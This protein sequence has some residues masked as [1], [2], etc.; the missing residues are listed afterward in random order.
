[1]FGIKKKT[2]LNNP[3]LKD[4]DMIEQGEG[5]ESLEIFFS[6]NKVKWFEKKFFQTMKLSEITYEGFSMLG[7]NIIKVK[8]KIFRGGNG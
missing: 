5:E 4:F 8:T 1:M 3:K 6:L 2:R 7:Y